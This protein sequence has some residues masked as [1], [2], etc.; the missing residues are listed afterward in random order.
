MTDGGGG[1]V[2]GGVGVDA[3]LTLGVLCTRAG[4]ISGVGALISGSR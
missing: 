1:G 2:G 3:L 4:F